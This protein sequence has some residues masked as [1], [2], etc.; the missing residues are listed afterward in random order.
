M[1]H[2]PDDID[3]VY[4]LLESIRKIRQ[5]IAGKSYEE[6]TQWAC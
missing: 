2:E 4:H 1:P 3:R 5:F 6:I